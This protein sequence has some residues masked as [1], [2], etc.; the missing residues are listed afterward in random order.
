MG[1]IA[2]DFYDKFDRIDLTEAPFTVRELMEMASVEVQEQFTVE[3]FRETRERIVR[4]LGE[5]V[6]F[7]YLTTLEMTALKPNIWAVRFKRVNPVSKKEFYQEVLFSIVTAGT[8]Q[9]LYWR[10]FADMRRVL[11][12]SFIEPDTEPPV[13][14]VVFPPRRR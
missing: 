1:M 12:K 7:R 9:L 2:S 4:E 6:S 13:T 5:P 3:K 10:V 8:S 14:T 11:T